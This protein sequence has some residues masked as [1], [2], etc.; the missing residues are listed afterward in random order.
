MQVLVVLAEADG[1]V[2]TREALFQRCWGGVFVG[3]DSLNRAIAAVR[4]LAADV[5]GGSFAIET[6]PR[7]GYRLSGQVRGVENAGAAVTTP[8]V[9]RR[10]LIAGGGA[11][12]IVATGCYWWSVRS[13]RAD[14]EFDRIIQQAKTA[15]ANEDTDPRT[16]RALEA[17]VEL[18]PDSASAW[19]L[20]ALFNAALAQFS[21]EKEAPSM[22]GRAQQAAGRAFA[23]DRNEPNALLAMFELQ[24][25]TLDWFTRDQ[26]LRRI[27]AIDPANV[28]AIAELVLLLQAAGMNAES[29]RWNERAIALVPLS[30]DFL[31]K[32]ALKLWLAER[33]PDADKVIDQVR[34]LYPANEWAWFVRFMIYAMTGR[35]QAARVMLQSSP[36]M[37]DDPIEA[38][39]W[40]E[41]LPVL[42]N[43]TPAAIVGARRACFDAAKKTNQV[44]GSAVIIL[45]ALRD[46]DGAFAVADGFLLSRGPIIHADTTSAKTV[47]QNAVD[48]VNMQWMFTPPCAVMR[49]D[50]RFAQLCDGIGLT[51]YWRRRGVRPD[52]QLT[53]T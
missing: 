4:K 25:S 53:E 36:R 37:I 2:V 38:G 29:R 14:A 43:P 20:L 19:G 47:L 26:R 7:T 17:A 30:L 9:S 32:R 44:H 13:S 52:Y 33:V 15:I 48:R 24:G 45:S 3:D 6:I 12:A 39:M 51:E 40:R 8:R 18:R 46:V 28:L 34:A 10:V 21:D 23:L 11:A 22:I 31:C 41:I 50:P 16:I 5:A 42:I 27:I 35:A 1:Q 49:A